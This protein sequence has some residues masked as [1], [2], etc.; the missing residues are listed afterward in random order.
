MRHSFRLPAPVVTLLSPSPTASKK[1]NDLLS[2]LVGLKPVNFTAQPGDALNESFRSSL[3]GFSRE[4]VSSASE[5]PVS[6]AIIHFCSIGADGDRIGP[7]SLIG[8]TDCRG[9]REESIQ[10]FRNYI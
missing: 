6:G 10:H 1:A 9:S 7:F 3:P 4:W 5:C 8:L 2:T